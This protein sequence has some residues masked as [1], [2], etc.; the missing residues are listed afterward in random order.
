MERKAPIRTFGSRLSKSN[1]I[2]STPPIVAS[3]VFDENEALQARINEVMS[4][5]IQKNRSKIRARIEDDFMYELDAL[6]SEDE[7]PINGGIRSKR[8]K[9]VHEVMEAGVTSQFFDEVEYLIEG[10]RVG[11]DRSREACLVDLVNKVCKHHGFGSKMRA[12]GM[13]AKGIDNVHQLIP[14]NTQV[15]NGI[16]F[17]LAFLCH[18]VRRMDA[19]ISYDQ[20]FS[21]IENILNNE[22]T[23]SFEHWSKTVLKVYKKETV[24][25]WLAAKMVLSSQAGSKDDQ[26]RVK[27]L[28]KKLLPFVWSYMKDCIEPLEL[29]WCLVLIEMYVSEMDDQCALILMSIIHRFPNSDGQRALVVLG[30]A[31]LLVV[32]T[33]PDHMSRLLS[34]SDT[35]VSKLINIFKLGQLDDDTL[36]CLFSVLINLVDRS[37]ELCDRLRFTDNIVQVLAKSFSTC[38]LVARNH[39]GLLLA[40]L[41]HDN[42]S[43]HQIITEYLTIDELSNCVIAFRDSFSSDFLDKFVINKD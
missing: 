39:L 3:V 14:K 2:S 18:D 21:L 37:E 30:C 17:L 16:A 36:V 19:F 32:L 9:T 35:F 24:G 42:Q 13:L 15:R 22:E 33:G 28:L 25:L 38:P 29:R 43:N 12:Y 5:P 34:Q 31:K 23:P 6:S 7:E 1:S 27:Q 26:L 8:N 40:I 4:G 11:S 20:L 41:S 10:L